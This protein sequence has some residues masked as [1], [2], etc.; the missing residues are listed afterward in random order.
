MSDQFEEIL[1]S[2]P[3]YLY[4]FPPL[5]I[6]DLEFF[7]LSEKIRAFNAMYIIAQKSRHYPLFRAENFAQKVNG[8]YIKNHNKR[9]VITCKCGA[10]IGRKDLNKHIKTTKHNTRIEKNMSRCALDKYV[11][12]V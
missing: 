11:F 10:I 9:R 7:T 2:D 8:E 3:E 4:T 6:D 5:Q 12:N 1:Y